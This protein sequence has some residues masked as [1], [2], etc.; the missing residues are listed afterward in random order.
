M[1]QRHDQMVGL[2]EEPADRHDPRQ[3]VIPLSHG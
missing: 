1:R 2:D 3:R